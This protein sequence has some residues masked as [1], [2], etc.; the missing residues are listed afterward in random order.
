AGPPA[1]HRTQKWLGVHGYELLDERQDPPLH[2]N[3]GR[4]HPGSTYP[5]GPPLRAAETRAER[6]L[7]GSACTSI[8]TVQPSSQNAAKEG[9]E[10]TQ[11]L[12]STH[13]P[14]PANSLPLAAQ[15]VSRSLQQ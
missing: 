1:H 15:R 12:R 11:T 6:R 5:A 4:P 13:T 10:R 9:M 2:Y 3:S 8:A 14:D 7:R